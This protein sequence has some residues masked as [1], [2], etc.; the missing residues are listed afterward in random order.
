[1]LDRL[2]CFQRNHI[3]RQQTKQLVLLCRQLSTFPTAV[4]LY[5][6]EQPVFFDWGLLSEQATRFF[7][8]QKNLNFLLF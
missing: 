2:F 4:Q 8:L 6:A 5:K 3:F 7:R 1:M